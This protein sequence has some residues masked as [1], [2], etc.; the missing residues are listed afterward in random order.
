M[1]VYKQSEYPCRV[2]YELLERLSIEQQ[3]YLDEYDYFLYM[4]DFDGTNLIC[5]SAFGMDEEQFET[6]EELTKW[7]AYGMC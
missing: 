7:V 1:T 6:I 5:L 3:K 4:K 2:E